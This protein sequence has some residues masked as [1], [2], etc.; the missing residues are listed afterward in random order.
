MVSD[1]MEPAEDFADP[2]FNR[3]VNTSLG[4]PAYARF[5]ESFRDLQDTVAAANPPEDVWET[6]R[7][8][9][10]DLIGEL[11]PWW[12]PERGQPSGTRI[13]LPGRGDP[14][15]LPFVPL[16]STDTFIRGRVVFRRLH[17]GGGGAAHGGTLP[18]LFDEVLGRLSN[19]GDRPTARTAYLKVNYRHITPLNTELDVEARLDRQDGRK[20]WITGRLSQGETL[21]ADAEGL[22]VQLRP[23]QP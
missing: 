22:F 17:L 7:Q 9:C 12:A 19:S 21:L 3:S 6:A 13:H 4:G 8:V 23:G 15:L 2:W 11:K 16:E 14:F 5:L 10:L 1:R 20:R 18:L